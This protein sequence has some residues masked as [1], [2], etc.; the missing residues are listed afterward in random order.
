[1]F[2]S[3]Q[4]HMQNEALKLDQKNNLNMMLE[5]RARHLNNVPANCY[6]KASIFEE[7]FKTYQQTDSQS[8]KSS[9]LLNFGKALE[10]V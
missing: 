6:D 9:D 7:N 1:M 4:T 5:C 8:K 2:K 3:H 10:L